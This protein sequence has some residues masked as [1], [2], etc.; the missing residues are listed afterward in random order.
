[1]GLG[2][3]ARDLHLSYPLPGGDVLQV[4]DIPQLDIPAG[5]AVGITGPSG[6]GKTSLLYVLVGLERPQQGRVSWG[7][8]EITRLD[9]EARDRWR[10][11]S[12]GFVFQDFHL[13]PGMSV[14]QNILLP[15]AFD[16]FTVP[17][18]MNLRAQTLLARVGLEN[19]RGAL[20]KLSRGEMQRVAVA[21][22][23]LFA[24]P[25]VVA[26]EPTA[27]LDSE[28]GRTVGD[29]LLEMCRQSGSTLVVVSHDPD[30]LGRL[31]TIHT[32]VGGRLTPRES[33]GTLRL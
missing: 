26:D 12:V 7:E 30:V 20:E 16:H 3:V 1:M 11:R 13:F 9:E 6:S 19:G 17:E 2:L 31:D 24:P 5:S 18:D 29:L 33:V 22:A 15:T 4:L 8:A 25:V 23:L 27:S 10:R 32:L 21:R 28:N 14:L